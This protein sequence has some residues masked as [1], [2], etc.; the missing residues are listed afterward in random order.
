MGNTARRDAIKVRA[1]VRDE[2]ALQLRL[3]GKTHDEI[4][5]LLGYGARNN[6]FRAV[7]KRIDALNRE[8]NETAAHVKAM[9]LARLDAMLA[10]LWKKAKAG[11]PQAI[12]RVLKIQERRA[13]YEGLDMPRALK[14]EVAREL[15]SNLEKLKAGLAPDVFEHVLS[16][17]AGEHG[18]APPSD[19]PS[20]AIED[21][22]GPE[23]SADG[24]A[25]P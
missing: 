24:S 16:V 20:G 9:E 21:A 25:A 8:C 1:L 12:D 13:A 23:P 14:V 10:G 3:S 17:L 18:E 6:A 11:D 5:K 4:A 2:Q 15:D 19:A 7:K 22:D